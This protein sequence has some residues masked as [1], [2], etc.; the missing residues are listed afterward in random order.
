MVWLYQ[1]VHF[2]CNLTTLEPGM[3]MMYAGARQT[4]EKVRVISVGFDPVY[5][6]RPVPISPTEVGRR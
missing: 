6:L 5:K 3:V 4:I 1:F 2:S